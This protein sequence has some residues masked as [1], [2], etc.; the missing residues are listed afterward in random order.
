MKK[1]V[2]LGIVIAVS[3]LLLWSV[4]DISIS[5]P[6]P[7]QKEVKAADKEFK[8]GDILFQISKSNQ[9]PLIQLG[10]MSKWSHCGVVIE[11]GDKL[12]VLEAS[13]VVKL[14][15]IKE[16]I[17]RGRGGVYHK[18]RVF[19]EEVKIK[20]KQYLGI[21][22]DLAFKFDNGKYYCSELVYV[23][24]RDQLGKELCKPKKVRDYYFVGGMKSTMKRRNIEL[25][26]EVV[27]PCDLL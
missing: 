9:S 2:L 22:Y 24:Y 19:D 23:I 11:K 26:Q 21:P 18:R 14:T 10:T 27:A 1:K 25:D 15:P 17:A 7:V 16:W 4:S 13:S 5:K 3:A 20:Y 8:E 12:Y 6:S